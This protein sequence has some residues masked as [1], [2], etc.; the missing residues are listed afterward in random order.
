[1]SVQLPLLNLT[2]EQHQ[3]ML[4]YANKR[5]WKP[6]F[7][8]FESL[9][10]YL[11]EIDLPG[12]RDKSA[13]NVEFTDH[14]TFFVKGKITRHVAT[15]GTEPNYR[16]IETI[17]EHSFKLPVSIDQ[18]SVTAKLV[19]GVLTITLPKARKRKIAVQ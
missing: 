13:V 5:S 11:I 3:E 7:I 15:N 17:F 6:Y 2:T 19:D 4:D 9:G 10:S 12:L 8:A 14:Q 16:P 18:D 1:M